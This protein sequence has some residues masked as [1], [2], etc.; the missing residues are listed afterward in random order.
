MRLRL[1]PGMSARARAVS[2]RLPG[3]SPRAHRDYQ[4]RLLTDAVM[5]AIAVQEPFADVFLE[6]LLP[7][8]RHDAALGLWHLA[9]AA[10]STV[11]ENAIRD[12]AREALGTAESAGRAARR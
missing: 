12:A 4:G 3:Q 10:T 8:L 11:P 7:L 5:T 2:L 9:V 6:G 1:V